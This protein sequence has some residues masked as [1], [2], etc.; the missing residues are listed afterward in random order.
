MNASLTKGV[1]RVVA[2]K[3][4]RE[5]ETNASGQLT[6]PE[7][8]ERRETKEPCPM[9]TAGSTGAR[10]INVPEKETAAVRR[11]GDP[12]V[13]AEQQRRQEVAAA[14]KPPNQVQKEVAITVIPQTA[15]PD[16][17]DRAKIGGC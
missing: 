7:A 14:N 17:G 16:P 4:A 11:D 2:A 15:S 12:P 6:V 3:E 5:R 1:E 8:A 10:D 9:E 13:I